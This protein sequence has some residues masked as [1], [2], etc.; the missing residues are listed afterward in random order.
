ME[1]K[2]KTYEIIELTPRILKTDI[3]LIDILTFTA[4]YIGAP[5]Y[6]IWKN[7]KLKLPLFSFLSN[8]KHLSFDGAEN[9]NSVNFDLEGNK[10]TFNPSGITK[11]DII[12]HEGNDAILKLNELLI[13]G[14]KINNK[15]LSLNFI[16]K[17]KTETYNDIQNKNDEIVFMSSPELAEKIAKLFG[18]NSNKF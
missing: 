4:Y 5:F 3:P 16:I 17:E 8:K 13:K 15:K 12:F 6:I 1:Y 18:I 11:T 10:K 9:K 14:F 2:Y 7:Y